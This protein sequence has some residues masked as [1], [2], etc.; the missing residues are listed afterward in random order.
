VILAPQKIPTLFGIPITRDTEQDI[1]DTA[2]ADGWIWAGRGEF[3][4]VFVRGTQALKLFSDPAYF[5]F[6]TQ[7]VTPDNEAFPK[8]I[9]GPYL[10][11]DL[12]AV[13]VE[14]L[15]PLSENDYWLSSQIADLADEAQYLGNLDVDSDEAYALSVHIS[16]DGVDALSLIIGLAHAFGLGTDLQP[17]N[18]MRRPKTGQLVFSDPLKI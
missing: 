6:L 11:Y 13:I 9:E 12:S 4:I 15:E 18:L 1:I 8:I 5:E 2:Q 16:N 7:I 3:S 10:G 17:Q 14:R